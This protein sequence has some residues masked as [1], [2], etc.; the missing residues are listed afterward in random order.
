MKLA[1]ILFVLIG[2]NIIVAQRQEYESDIYNER[3]DSLLTKKNIFVSPQPKLYDNMPMLRPDPNKKFTMP[4]FTPDSTIVNKMP[5]FK[6]EYY[7]K[8]SADTVKK[9]LPAPPF[10]HKKY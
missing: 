8:G 5:F 1:A 2:C 10:S 7:K 6:Q 3:L 4:Y 9:F